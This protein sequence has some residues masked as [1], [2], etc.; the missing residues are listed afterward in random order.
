[1]T[2]PKSEAKI[3]VVDFS[4]WNTNSTARQQ[5]AQEIV[6]ACKKVGFVYI[7]NHSLPETM[8]DE[9]FRW[10]EQFFNLAQ[11]AKLQAPHPPGWDVHRGYSWPGLE[12]VSQAMSGSADGDGTE[13]LREI[14]DIKES[15]DIGSDGNKT[16][17]N[18]WLPE[19]ILPGLKEFM[20]RFY[21]ECSRVG[22]EILQALAMGLDLDENHLLNKHSGHNNQLRL[23]HYPP[24]PAEVFESNRA[25]RCPPHTDWSSITM[26]FQDDCGGLE[27]ED[28]AA[29]GS[30]LPA[31]PIKNAIV[32]NVGDLLQMWSNGLSSCSHVDACVRYRFL[33]DA[34][35]DVDILRSTNH[36]VTLPP[37][38]NRFEGDQR[39]TR[40]R[41]SIPYF[42]APDPD[43]IIE[44]IPS[45][46]RD[47]MPAKYD[48]ITQ[49]GYNQMR[50]SMQY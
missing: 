4:T 30:Y 26:L 27:V 5:V 42:M 22:G 32:M 10:S 12:K 8:L 40:G 35:S 2:S 3:P 7:T 41:F 13:Q 15:Y 28:L 34:N 11:D 29:L 1:M 6:T 14:P 18:Q 45:C 36:R 49:A 46:V 25:A 44:C 21:W 43:E 31:T 16:Q 48:P 37:L 17:P 19:E 50:A 33:A 9:A 20:R 39:M 38:G 47:D 24:A 23:L